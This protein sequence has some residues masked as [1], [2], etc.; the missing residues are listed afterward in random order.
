MFMTST[1]LILRVNIR[2]IT[3]FDNSCSQT[4]FRLTTLEIYWKW[5][6]VVCQCEHPFLQDINYMQVVDGKLSQTCYLVALDSCYKTF[7]KR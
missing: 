5:I 6:Y 2:Y 4:L 7:C 3:I 1:S